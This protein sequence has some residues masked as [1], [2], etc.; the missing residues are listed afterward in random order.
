RHPLGDGPGGEGAVLL[1][2]KVVVQAAC[3]V[4]LDDED[5]LFRRPGLAREGL[6]RPGR[7]ALAAGLAERAQGSFGFYRFAG[8][9]IHCNLLHLTGVRRWG[10]LVSGLRRVHSRFPLVKTLWMVW[11]GVAYAKTPM[12]RNF[13]R[14]RRHSSSPGVSSSSASASSSAAL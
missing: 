11:K 4:P 6:G 2:P 3:I 14:R 10:P 9:C 1:E 13:A 8:A 7:V 5:R 12:P